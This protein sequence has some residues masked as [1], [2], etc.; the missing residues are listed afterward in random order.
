MAASEPT[1]TAPGPN[2]RE[3]WLRGLEPHEQGWSDKRIAEAPGASKGAV[4]QRLNGALEDGRPETLRHRWPP[5][6]TRPLSTEQHT[7]LAALLVQGAEA[8]D[9]VSEVWMCP[10]GIG[11]REA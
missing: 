10:P 9:F 5:G 7:R 8:H 6:A 2:R 11:R 4:S 1:A 3:V